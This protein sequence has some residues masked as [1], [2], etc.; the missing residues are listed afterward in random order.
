MGGN[1]GKNAVEKRVSDAEC[2]YFDNAPA[3]S[4]DRSYERALREKV[5]M[6]VRKR[7]AEFPESQKCSWKREYRNAEHKKT[8][9]TN[10]I[11]CFM[12]ETMR[13]IQMF[14]QIVSV[15]SIV[16]A[17][18]RKLFFCVSQPDV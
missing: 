2:A 15:H 5:D 8:V 3:C 10:Q 12:Q 1:T 17:I 11:A 14:K 6:G 18:D 16:R 9:R 7:T 13:R 4:F